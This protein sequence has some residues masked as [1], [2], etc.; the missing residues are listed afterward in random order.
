MHDKSMINEQAIF[1]CILVIDESYE[2]TM[3]DFKKFF[4]HQCSVLNLTNGQYC[5]N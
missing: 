4:H 2:K 1:Y 3:K 5:E